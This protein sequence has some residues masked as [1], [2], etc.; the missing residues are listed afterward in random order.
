MSTDISDF[1][2][3]I[4]TAALEHEALVKFDYPRHGYGDPVARI[5]QVEEYDYDYGADDWYVIGTQTNG[6]PLDNTRKFLC[7]KIN[8]PVAIRPA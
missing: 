7:K 1:N 8:G 2:D 3:S 6:D 5:V 4:L